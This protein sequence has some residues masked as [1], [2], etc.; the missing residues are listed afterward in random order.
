M[1]VFVRVGVCNEVILDYGS[2]IGINKQANEHRALTGGEATVT[3][4]RAPA[5]FAVCFPKTQR[6]A[7]GPRSPAF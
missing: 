4:V 2:T 6:E 1:C 5:S 3:D 7:P